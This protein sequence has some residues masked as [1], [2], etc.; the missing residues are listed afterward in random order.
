[1]SGNGRKGHYGEQHAG[2]AD[3][4]EKGISVSAISM[5]SGLPGYKRLF[6]ELAR[7]VEE[8]T[9]IPLPVIPYRFADT[10]EAFR[11]MASAKHIGKNCHYSGTCRSSK[12]GDGAAPGRNDQC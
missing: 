11:Y 5:D 3:F 10:E 12:A 2:N 7:H 1:M 9:F 6:R 8:G 4:F